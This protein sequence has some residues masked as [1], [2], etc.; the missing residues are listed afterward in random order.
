MEY[1]QLG[2]SG[3]SVPVIGLGGTVFG[4]H[5]GF[6][7]YNNE[8][9]AAGIIDRA[10]DLG[11]NLIDTADIY[12]DGVSETYIGKAIAGRREDFLIASKVGIST[13]DGPNDT[14]LSRGRIMASIE[15][16]LRRL[17]TD[18]IDLYYAHLPDPT[19]PQEESI[20]AFDDLVRQGKVRYLGCSNYAGW[21]IAEARGVAAHL[22][23]SPFVASQSRYSLLRR[24]IEED[25]IPACLN[26]GMGI[27]AYE[28]LAQ[29]VL[30]GKY[31]RGEAIQPNTRAWQNPTGA[32]QGYLAGDGLPTV[33][34]LA[35]WSD[36]N[37]HR[38]S[39]LALAWLLAK[40]YVSS[41]LVGVTGIQQL[42]ANVAAA[43][44]RLTD[45]Q[46]R[47]VAGVLELE[48]VP[49]AA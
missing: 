14:G 27:V 35:E 19:T 31:G 20:G 47:Q 48:P 45:E 42:E 2:D 30:T 10:L 37:G 32:V 24:D 28:P 21:Q 16:T 33:E 8:K 26:F 3:L 34:R 13:G 7:H 15:G 40:P 17:Q 4:Q 11:V 1:R 39:E 18:Y 23:L 49:D 44:W 12:G 5:A 25:A 36:E 6:T 38:V 22:G 46:M 41:V 43:E 29:G 9:A